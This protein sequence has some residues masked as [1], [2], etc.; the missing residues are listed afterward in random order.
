MR[1]FGRLCIA[2]S[3]LVAGAALAQISVAQD[4][5]D[6]CLSKAKNACSAKVGQTKSVSYCID[7]VSC[8][9]RC[10]Y[11]QQGN[12]SAVTIRYYRSCNKAAMIAIKNGLEA[13]LSAG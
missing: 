5:Y 12:N 10:T 8:D 4:G 13:L 2:A 7:N 11:D 1:N 3:S 6:I 9:I